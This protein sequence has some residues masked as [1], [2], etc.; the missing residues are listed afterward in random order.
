MFKKSQDPLVESARQAMEKGIR[1]RAIEVEINE[2]FGVESRKALPNEFHAD[3]DAL[4]SEAKSCGKI[5]EGLKDKI[6][7]VAKKLYNDLPSRRAKIEKATERAMQGSKPKDWARRQSAVNSVVKEEE[8]E[9]GSPLRKL[10]KDYDDAAKKK[11][12]SRAFDKLKEKDKEKS[13]KDIKEDIDLAN[14]SEEEMDAIIVDLVNEGYDVNDIADFFQLSESEQLDEISKKLAGEYIK[15]SALD[16]GDQSNMLHTFRNSSKSTTSDE[17]RQRYQGMAKD[18]LKKGNNRLRGIEKAA[19]KLSGSAKVVAKEDVESITEKI[20]DDTDIIKAWKKAA[21]N[22][23]IRGGD[24]HREA[25]AGVRKHL[26]R[27]ASNQ[28]IHNAIKTYNSHQDYARGQK[29]SVNE[30]VEDKLSKRQKR[31]IFARVDKK[32]DDVQTKILGR[33]ADI[34]DHP[35]DVEKL[36]SSKHIRHHDR[37]NRIRGRVDVREELQEGVLRK[38]DK[39]LGSPLQKSRIR[40]KNGG[41]VKPDDYPSGPSVTKA[42]KEKTKRFN[43]DPDV[44]TNYASIGGQFGHASNHMTGGFSKR[45]ARHQKRSI[46]EDEEIE[47]LIDHLVNEG[48]EFDEIEQG[49]EEGVFDDFL[50]EGLGTNIMNR[51]SGNRRDVKELLQYKSKVHGHMKDRY[52]ERS[53]KSSHASWKEPVGSTRQKNYKQDAID[54]GEKAHKHRVVSDSLGR[55]ANNLSRTKNYFKGKK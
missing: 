13:E 12:V 8:L 17:S 39:A 54:S 42:D 6:T 45:F 9:E 25:I 36:N 43:R 35:E 19:D 51:I 22:G 55:K 34:F 29:K 52:V 18:A 37:L 48:F 2:A 30:R 41:K 16:F 11:R 28:E 1:D 10:S 44:I 7:K 26:G 21:K 24:G 20:D 40:S 3:Y 53:E 38:I 47:G 5:D 31:K 14:L 23:D 15:K 46:K 27:K 4:I 33:R 49:L 50:S 32:M